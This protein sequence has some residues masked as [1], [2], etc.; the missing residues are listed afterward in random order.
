MLN[1]RQLLALWAVA[2]ALMVVTSIIAGNVYATG[3]LKEGYLIGLVGLLALGAALVFS[4][5][6]L[7]TAQMSARAR[8]TAKGALTVATLAWAVLMIFP[9]L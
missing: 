1:S 6:W 9:F 4:W 7:R 2:V 8:G 5:R 3:R